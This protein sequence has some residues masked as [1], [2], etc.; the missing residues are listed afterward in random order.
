MIID[1]TGKILA[2]PAR[3]EETILYAEVDLSAVH[4]ARRLFDPVGH[5]SRPDVFQLQVDTRPRPPVVFAGSTIGDEGTDSTVAALPG[6]AL[7]RSLVRRDRQW[8]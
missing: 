3:R 5:Y 7:T 6:T 4:S 8:R 1:P 2:G